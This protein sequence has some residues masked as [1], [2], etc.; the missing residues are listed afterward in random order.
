MPPI[1]FAILGGVQMAI[2]EFPKAVALVKKAKDFFT[3]LVGD[4]IITKDQQDKLHA[5]ID[6][7]SAAAQR[8]EIPPAWTVEADPE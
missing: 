2:Q 8:G 1:V 5:R 3:G 7:L 4:G 6:E